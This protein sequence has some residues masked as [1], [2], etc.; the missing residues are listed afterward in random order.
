MHM[1]RKPLVCFDKM[2]LYTRNERQD[3]IRGLKKIIG[4]ISDNVGY[5]V[6]GIKG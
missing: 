1:L 2:Y 5:D 4:Q 6:M 3:K